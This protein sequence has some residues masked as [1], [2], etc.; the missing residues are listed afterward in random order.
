MRILYDDLKNTNLSVEILEALCS[1]K[2]CKKVIASDS[3]YYLVNTNIRLGDN[4][5]DTNEYNSYMNSLILEG[6]KYAQLIK[7]IECQN[8]QIQKIK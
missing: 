4:T 7:P 5:I 2:L 8:Q 1:Q 3:E 6:F